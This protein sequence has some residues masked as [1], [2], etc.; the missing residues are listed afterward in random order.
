MK[1]LSSWPNYSLTTE[2]YRSIQKE[3]ADLF[4]RFDK[5]LSSL[6]IGAKAPD[7]DL[8]ESDSSIEI[9][10]E[11]PGVDEK[12]INVRTDGN[13]LVV[14]GEKKHELKR[15]EKDW[16]VEE[17]SYGSF[18]RSMLLPF[19]PRDETIKAH[20]DKGVLHISIKKPAG[21]LTSIKTITI[22]TK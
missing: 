21:S 22:N 13:S 2:P 11:L 5:T 15:N 9:S 20:L 3:M 6:D 17:R 18:Y 8:S 4:R 1:S 14:S 12:D 16:Y 7:M 19:T 10:V